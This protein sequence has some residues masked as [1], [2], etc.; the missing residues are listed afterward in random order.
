MKIRNFKV[1]ME[2]YT[3]IIEKN[4]VKI[5]KIKTKKKISDGDFIKKFKDIFN[6]YIKTLD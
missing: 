5:K 4:I 1:E 3:E 2:K 6:K